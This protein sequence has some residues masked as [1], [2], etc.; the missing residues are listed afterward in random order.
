[1]YNKCTLIKIGSKGVII[2]DVISD[3]DIV[4]FSIK[5][6]KINLSGNTPDIIH[7]LRIFVK[8]S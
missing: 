4:V 8:M 7:G 2:G 3:K 1:M 5:D 6:I